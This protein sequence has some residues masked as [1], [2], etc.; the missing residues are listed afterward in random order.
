M[1]NN[2]RYDGVWIEA[3]EAAP[4]KA[5]HHGRVVFADWLRGYGLVAIIDHGGGYEFIWLQ[6]EPLFGNR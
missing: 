6:P 5:V 2:I 3:K 4:V 1:R